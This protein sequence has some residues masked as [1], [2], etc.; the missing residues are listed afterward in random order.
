MRL[1]NLSWPKHASNNNNHRV[2]HN[3]QRVFFLS[4]QPPPNIHLLISVFL[5]T[6]FPERCPNIVHEFT[7]LLPCFP[8]R[9][10]QINIFFDASLFTPLSAII[11]F[12]RIEVRTCFP[13]VRSIYFSKARPMS[14]HCLWGEGRDVMVTVSGA[15]KKHFVCTYSTIV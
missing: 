5:T 15:L 9:C 2:Y 11:T 1:L 12:L 7:N 4:K 10:L 6:P 3:E 13:N 8:E 14:P